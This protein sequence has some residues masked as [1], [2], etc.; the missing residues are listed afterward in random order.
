MRGAQNSPFGL[1]HLHAFSR[2]GLCDSPTHDGGDAGERSTGVSTSHTGCEFKAVR[3]WFLVRAFD[4][5]AF[6]SR[7]HEQLNANPFEPVEAEVFG[8]PPLRQG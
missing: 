7:L 1:R 4:I 2:L 3:V 6:R 5:W 8:L